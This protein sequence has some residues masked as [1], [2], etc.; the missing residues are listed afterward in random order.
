MG[1]IK[2]VFWHIPDNCNFAFLDIYAWLLYSLCLWN[3]SGVLK[4]NNKPR[5]STIVQEMDYLPNTVFSM[6]TEIQ[7]FI[8]LYIILKKAS[9]SVLHNSAL[10][11]NKNVLWTCKM[12]HHT[13]L[14]HPVVLPGRWQEI[15]AAQTYRR[16]WD[17]TFESWHCG[18]SWAYGQTCLPSRG[19]FFL[20]ISRG[21]PSG[22][23]SSILP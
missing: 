18:R 7:T 2:D 3:I 20:C 14:Q 6:I 10:I 9:R 23:K 15:S 13:Q 16:A 5:C 21:N 4:T 8:F 11:K 1:I 19:L 12:V 17:A 22:L